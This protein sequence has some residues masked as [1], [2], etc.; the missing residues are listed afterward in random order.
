MNICLQMKQLRIE[1]SNKSK[2]ESFKKSLSE[3]A[4][5]AL[6]ELWG[7]HYKKTAKRKT[8]PI[9]RGLSGLSL[10]RSDDSPDSQTGG[11]T[12][13]EVSK[14]AQNKVISRKA[15]KLKSTQIRWF[16]WWPGKWLDQSNGGQ[17]HSRKELEN[18]SRSQETKPK[19]GI[20]TA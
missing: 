19:T 16:L 4:I 10:L 9:Q 20:V 8:A 18:I 1:Y 6:Y 5:N 13:W 17:R 14:G 3:Y 2:W 7:N 11:W 15:I 12:S